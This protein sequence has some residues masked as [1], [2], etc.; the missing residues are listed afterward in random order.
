[1][2]S[3]AIKNALEANGCVTVIDLGKT[4]KAA[5]TVVLASRNLHG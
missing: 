5:K 1:M 2:R 3:M 4:L